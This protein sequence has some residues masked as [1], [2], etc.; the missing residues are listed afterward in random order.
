VLSVDPSSDDLK[1]RYEGIKQGWSTPQEQRDATK[2]PVVGRHQSLQEQLRKSVEGREVEVLIPF[3][4]AVRFQS[5]HAHHQRLLNNFFRLVAAH[6]FV[7]QDRRLRQCTGGRT[8]RIEA[9]LED[10]S[11]AYSLIRGVTID[12]GTDLMPEASA[13]LFTA[14]KV[15]FKERSEF[16][17]LEI[18]KDLPDWTP[19]RIRTWIGP[20]VESDLLYRKAGPKNKALYGLT[21]QGRLAESPREP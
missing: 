6:A 18:T 13:E 9:T 14:I 20:L 1:K 4:A 5:K 10:Y 2:R 17:R 8:L 3:A 15:K 19:K 11:A 12:T 16:T 21:P 7:E